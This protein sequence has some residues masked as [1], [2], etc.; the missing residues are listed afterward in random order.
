MKI[1]HVIVSG[2]VLAGAIGLVS[3]TADAA[4]PG[5]TFD[6]TCGNTT[7]V[8]AGNGNGA[9]TPA[10][11]T[12]SNLVYVPVSFGEFHGIVRDTEGIIVGEFIDPPEVKGKN[13]TGVKNTTTCQFSFTEVS[14]GSDPEFPL[15]FTFEGSGEVAGFLSQRGR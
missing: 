11:S 3:G 4:G 2:L 1:R 8:V 7:A 13:G 6:L 12:T 15:G 10:R 14:D 5:I 9:W